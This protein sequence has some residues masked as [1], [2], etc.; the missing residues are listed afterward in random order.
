L[1]VAAAAALMLP[2]P[3]AQALIVEVYPPTGAEQTF[4]V[5]AGVHKVTV[6]VLGGKGGGTADAAG[7]N[8]VAVIGMLSVT[9]GQTL[10]IEVG[11]N[12]KPQVLGGAGG[13]NGGGSA[14]GSGGGGG[15][16]GGASDI[17]T[18]PRTDGLNP[19]T[20]LIISAGGGGAGGTGA[21]GIGGKGGD[22][23]QDGG[24]ALGGDSAGAGGAKG[25]AGGG[26]GG[27]GCNGDG[28]SGEIGLGGDGFPG[29]VSNEGG[30]G[31]GGGLYGGGGGGGGCIFGGGG[32][33][34]GSDLVPPGGAKLATALE[35]RIEV[36][37]REPPTISITSPVEG[38]TIP[39]GQVM[40]ASYGCSSSENVS[41]KECAGS[42]ANGAALDTSTLGPHTL[43]VEAEDAEKGTASRSVSYMV[44]AAPPAPP[45]PKSSNV[46][47]DTAISARPK[48][49]VRTKKK[50]AKV[51]FSFS[52]DQPGATFQCKL[53]KGAFAPC[54]SPKS[55]RVKPGKH[56][57]SVEAV[58]PGGSDVTPATF[59][60]K[61]K[62]KK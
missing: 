11:G 23:G 36:A 7:G 40:T 17:R 29:E 25:T 16:G 57:F 33:G 44:V 45:A 59:S 2:A 27:V 24:T 32:G 62:K 19:D 26:E 54:T 51:K 41:I 37:Y 50:K 8:S 53:D 52:S 12:G 6:G 56:S 46:V 61:V 20:R 30:G 22:A 34:G 48:P 47:P 4:A 35:P 49:T 13:F 39:Q 31:G 15:G 38:A 14:S 5:P 43:T 58:A 18:K 21:S 55:Y 28:E 42:V 1:I 3:P 60:F 9:P 10:Y